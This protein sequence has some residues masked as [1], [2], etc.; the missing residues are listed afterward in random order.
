[1]YPK[2]RVLRVSEGRP[3]RLPATTAVAKKARFSNPLLCAPS[4]RIILSF[5]CRALVDCHSWTRGQKALQLGQW[6]GRS[7]QFCCRFLVTC[8][9]TWTERLHKREEGMLQPKQQES[10]S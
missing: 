8:C 7:Q 5:V 9:R 4:Q 10:A 3:A 2:D 6:S 1:M